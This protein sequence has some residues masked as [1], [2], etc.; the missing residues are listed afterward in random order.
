MKKVKFKKILIIDFNDSFTFN[1]V[2]EIYKSNQNIHV[3]NYR[4]IN[5]DFVLEYSKEEEVVGVVF[6][7]GPGHPDDY[8]TVFNIIDYMLR[9]NQ[10]FK[11]LN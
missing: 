2:S 5:K 7:P 4:Q 9:K 11:I 1:I 3:V 10:K 8:S 6:G